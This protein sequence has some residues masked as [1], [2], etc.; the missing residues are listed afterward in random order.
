MVNDQSN[1]PSDLSLDRARQARRFIPDVFLDTPQYEDDGLS[2]ALACPVT[3][4]VESL[5]PVRS[6]K[7]RGV[8]FALRD[9]PP[10]GTVVCSS[11]GNFGQAVAFLGRLRGAKVRI[12][13]PLQLNPVKRA[14]M[15]AFGADLVASDGDLDD[16]RRAAVQ[17]ANTTGAHLIVDGVDPAVAEGAATIAEELIGHDTFDAIVAPVGDGSLI[18][19]LALWLRAH[20]PRTRII[21]VNP[22]ST[23]AMYESW[24]AGRPV[25]VESS[26]GFAEG[27]SVPCP[28]PEALARVTR[29]VDD[30]V[31]VNDQE[32]REGMDLIAT[33]LALLAEPAGAAGI[34]AIAHRRVHGDRIATIISGANRHP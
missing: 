31:L 8:G 32:L 28:H 17:D 30:I 14:R 26:S 24:R 3:V 2:A 5:N 6:F 10:G 23:P 4:K 18:C 22:S 27:I 20:A 33:H 19:G 16:A 7:G 11:S 1:H 13:T 25:E 29:L 21:G 12:H 15:L 9:L 34:A